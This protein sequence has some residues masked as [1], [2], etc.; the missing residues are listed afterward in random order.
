MFVSDVTVSARTSR[1]AKSSTLVAPRA[2]ASW[3]PPPPPW[4]RSAAK[5]SR[6][7]W[8]S[9]RRWLLA[10][11][12]SRTRASLARATSSLAATSSLCRSAA[13]SAAWADASAARAAGTMDWVA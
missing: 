9:A 2:T 3:E 5:L 6:F 13:F 10:A 7:V 1:L 12:A 8:V 4:N 11:V